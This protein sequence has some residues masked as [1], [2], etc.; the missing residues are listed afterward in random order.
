MMKPQTEDTTIVERYRSDF[1][2]KEHVGSVRLHTE[3][4]D[5]RTTTGTSPS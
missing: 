3:F 1:K 4:S 2:E 5:G